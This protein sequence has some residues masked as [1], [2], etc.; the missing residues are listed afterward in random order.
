V[1]GNF[2]LAALQKKAR[3][4]SRERFKEQVKSFLEEKMMTIERGINKQGA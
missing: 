1:E 3:L 2:Q 4:F